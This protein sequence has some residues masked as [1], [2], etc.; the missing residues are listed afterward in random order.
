M[1]T[2]YRVEYALKSHRRDQLIEWIKALLAVPFVLHSQP[3]GIISSEDG[4][5]Q[6]MATEAHR[7]YA[8]IMS[9]VESM[10]DQDISFRL[11]QNPLP[12]K[13]NL[14]VPTAGPFFTRLPLEAAFKYQD[15]VRY[16]SSRRYVSP[17]FND[18]RLILNSA[19]VMAV[20]D[21]SLE[22]A[23][24]D[25]D[26]T[27]YEDGQCLEPDSPIIP[28]LLDLLRRNVKIGIVTAAGYA[29][30]EGYYTRLHG[31]L[32]AVASS[33]TLT[34][35]QK[36]S[37]VIVG[38]EANYLFKMALGS[39]HLLEPVPRYQWLTADMSRWSETDITS[40]LNTAEEALT[41]CVR[42]MNLPATIIRKDLAVGII[43]REPHIRLPRE[44]LEETV[45][46]VQKTLELSS[47]GLP[48][49]RKIPFC[50]FN[51]GRDVFVDIGDK[52]WGVTVAQKFFRA[53]AGEMIRPENTLHV[54]DQ[55]LSAGS[56]DFKARSVATTAW[57]A[58]PNETVDLL[59][60]LSGLLGKKRE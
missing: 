8:E 14:L 54:G 15:S 46:V 45:L 21:G 13:L 18:V 49:G 3:A 19:Q 60:E 10:I 27:L 5:V 50:A 36:N 44:S 57:I 32:T 2:R 58:S 43:P 31:L 59:D 55:F 53:S 30:A 29:T 6:R 22:L 33:T 47:M 39:P 51:G 28:R 25:G 34:D 17:S 1:T 38:G 56:N 24:F 23:T 40:L 48:P 16:I 20:T 12:S 37:V 26:V 35:A 52:S 11:S 41:D 9:D 42:S 4:A 7:R